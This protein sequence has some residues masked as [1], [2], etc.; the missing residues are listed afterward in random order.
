MFSIKNKSEISQVLIVIIGLSIMATI[1]LAVSHA[2]QDSIDPLPESFTLLDKQ[3]VEG[4]WWIFQYEECYF[5]FSKHDAQQPLNKTLV[6]IQVPKAVYDK[7]AVGDIINSTYSW[8]DPNE[9]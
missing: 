3:T 8:F 6:T 1:S 9:W 5:I 2:T 4:G 7:Y